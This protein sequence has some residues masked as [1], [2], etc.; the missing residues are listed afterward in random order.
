MYYHFLNTNPT[1]LLPPPCIERA[2]AKS[3][4]QTNS[5]E[6]RG[7]VYVTKNDLQ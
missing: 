5:L 2:N 4:S 1:K 7:N 6:D 3:L